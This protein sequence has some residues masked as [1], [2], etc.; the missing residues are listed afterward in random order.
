MTKT[1]SFEGIEVEYDD[2]QLNKWSIQK[3]L[4]TLDGQFVALDRIFCGK[5][6][7]IAEKLGDDMGQM[8]SLLQRVVAVNGNA[9]KN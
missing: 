8:M 9:G 4:T 6:D 7:E 1:I 5:S 3:Q 2:S